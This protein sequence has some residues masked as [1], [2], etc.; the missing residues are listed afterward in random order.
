MMREHKPLPSRDTSSTG[1]PA[2]EARSDEKGC[3]D[4]GTILCGPRLP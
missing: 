1:Y 3:G 2:P 4:G